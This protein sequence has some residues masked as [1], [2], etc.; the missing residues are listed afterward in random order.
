M[1]IHLQQQE[2]DYM[3]QA[4]PSLK[5]VPKRWG[6]FGWLNGLLKSC[7]KTIKNFHKTR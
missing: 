5:S 4:L 2:S 1:T 7:K 6:L 3:S